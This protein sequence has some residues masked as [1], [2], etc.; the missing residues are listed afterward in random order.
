MNASAP[1]D[2]EARVE[3][4]TQELTTELAGATEKLQAVLDAATQVAIIATDTQGLITVFNSGAKL[5]LGYSAE[6][7]VGKQTPAIMHLESEFIEHGRKLNEL[8][9]RPILGFD[10]F[11][12]FARQG[13]H[14]EREWTYVRKNGSHLTVSV[15]VTA[16]R[17]AHGQ[18]TGF[19][20]VAKDIT[21]RKRAEEELLKAKEA[22]EAATR[23]KS[24]FLVNMS[25]E[26]RTPM[27]GVLGMTTLLLDS[28]LS[29]EQRHQAEMISKSGELLLS[30][31]NDILD[32]SKIEARKLVFE[33]LDF[34]LQEAV[35]GCLELLAPQA[36]DKGLE[37]ACLFESNVPTRL[38]GDPRRLRQVLTNFVNNAIKFTER[39][40][41]AVKVSMDNQTA[42][43]A[44]LRFEVK[45]T[46]IGIPSDVKARLFQPFSQADASMSRKF[47]GTGLGLAISRQLVEIM[48]GQVGIK[49]APSHGSIFWFTAR[50]ARQ[51]EGT[52]KPISSDGLA[53]GSPPATRAAPAQQQLRILLAE[54]NTINREVAQGLLGKLGYRA[55]AVANGTE[56]LAALR[57]IRYDVILMDCQMPELDGYEATRR[58]RRFEQE[59]VAPF[60]WKTPLYI[61]A[62]TA[63]AMEG[64]REK[65]L[66]AGMN[67]Y[68]G[69]PL[70]LEQLQAALARQGGGEIKVSDGAGAEPPSAPGDTAISAEAPLVDLDRLREVSDDDP[71][72]IG[73]LVNIYLNQAVLLLDDL[74]AAIQTN[75]SDAVAQ[76]AHK[77]AGS[78]VSC[79]VN[80]FTQPLRTLERLG[81]T[82]DLSGAGILFDQ[83]RQAFPRVRIL[84]H[85]FLRDIQAPTHYP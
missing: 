50:V 18:L 54:D 36:K 46:G 61:V 53:K 16:L 74:E 9:G 32:F 79:G 23:A 10:V 8:F 72:R 57:Q 7:M 77:L 75:S 62:L 17:D 85:Q 84:L 3:E 60:D 4:R 81:H 47:G 21:L 70:R 56:V 40:E 64:D 39:G 5:M 48:H 1:G 43:E 82:G 45:D 78:S 65:C 71:E 13:K 55:D 59:R 14:E 22:A 41:V 15:V 11:V 52:S 26:I 51:P 42:T 33:T 76:A 2:L 37:L 66:M 63:H 35:E 69:K 28:E 29:Q 68:L 6:E 24:D 73:Q 83:V 49:S 20:G 27:N 19:L 12:E 80:A 34:D 58:I 38:R 44:L 30:I 25:H 31:I 67:N